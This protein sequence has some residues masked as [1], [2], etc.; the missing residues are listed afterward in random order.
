MLLTDWLK[1]LPKSRS[2]FCAPSRISR[3][4]GS[5]VSSAA[6]LSSQPET[7]EKR[8]LLS[9]ADILLTDVSGATG[10]QVEGESPRMLTV[11]ETR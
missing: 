5:R 3:R 8:T 10:F 7:L 1:H 4:K 11:S 2:N 9:A 6:D